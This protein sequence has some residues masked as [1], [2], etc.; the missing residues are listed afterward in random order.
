MRRYDLAYR[1]LPY[2]ITAFD[3]GKIRQVDILDKHFWEIIT[4]DMINDFEWSELII[5]HRILSEE[6]SV[7]IYIF[8]EP[9]I[10]PEAKFG[11]LFFN[12]KIKSTN[13]FTLEK[14]ISNE[15]ESWV[16]GSSSNN[17]DTH[18]N[19]GSLKVEPTLDNFLNVVYK[20]YINKQ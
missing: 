4:K 18:L 8:P 3:D 20:N 13:Y 17:G 2:L 10:M 19:F 6:I 1:F 5:E 15:S 11:L 16:I 14:S 9:Q 7:G 12:F